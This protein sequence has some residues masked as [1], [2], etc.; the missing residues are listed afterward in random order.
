MRP[1]RKS[2][3]LLAVVM[4][5]VS[6]VAG[7]KLPPPTEEQKAKAAE[8]KAKAAEAAKKG[9]E[10]LSEAQD[11]VAER[12]IKEQKAK[13]IVVKPTPIALPAPAATSSTSPP[14]K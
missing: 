3:L 4:L 1:K 14:K 12:Y 5:S 13:G 6:G 10:L 11:Q 7:A 8:A 9:A 2:M